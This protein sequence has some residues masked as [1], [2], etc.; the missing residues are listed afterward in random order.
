MNLALK[1]IEITFR[2]FL[3]T[4]LR[5]LV[6]SHKMPPEDIEYDSCKYLFV[7]QD[8]IGDVLVSTPL[9]SALK[10][11][12]PNAV[13]DVLLST[14]NHFVLA[15]DHAIRKRWM[16]NKQL[17]AS[18]RM[19]YNI[20][21]EK[22]DFV[23]DLMDNPSAT[24]TVICLL[25]DARW[26]VGL[27][28]D[29]AYA[30]DIVVPLISRKD[31]HIVD[32]IARLLVPFGIDPSAEDLRIRFNVPGYATEFSNRVFEQNKLIRG[33]TMGINISAGHEVRFWGIDNFRTLITLLASKYRNKPILLLSKPS[34][35]SLAL[36]ISDGFDNVVLAP[37]TNS[38]DEFAGLIRN[39]GLLITPDTSAVHLAAAFS[40]PSV[41]MYVQSDK[42]LRIWEPYN[43]R[44]EALVADVDDLRVISPE[45]VFQAV[46][47]ITSKRKQI[48]SRDRIGFTARS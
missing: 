13:I 12:Y 48:Q 46:Q 10:N 43:S 8:R 19:M 1:N 42:N 29:N 20:R 45:E 26:T 16:Y 34:H 40:V 17:F 32:R 27:R 39:L 47:R 38:F 14:N 18:M 35:K 24:S 11:K 31:A 6:R 41:V 15:N 23:I 21:R 4:S 30:Y 25:S 5:L 28:K 37:P 44:S 2:R 22:Y 3:I 7:R 9:F 33:K 36:Q